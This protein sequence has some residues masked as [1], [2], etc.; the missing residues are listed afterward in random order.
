MPFL[1][2]ISRSRLKELWDG[3]GGEEEIFENEAFVKAAG[4]FLSG[5]YSGIID[6]LTQAVNEGLVIN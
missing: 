4:Q 5:Q 2:D 6:L 1:D 3:A